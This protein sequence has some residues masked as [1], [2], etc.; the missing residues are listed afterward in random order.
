MFDPFAYQISRRDRGVV[1]NKIRGVVVDNVD[2]D[3]DNP[4]GRI[5]VRAR[6]IHDQFPDDHL[7]WSM[8][9]EGFGAGTA[10]SGKKDIPPIGAI[11]F[12]SHQDD[13][14]YHP[15][16]HDGPSTDDKNIK[17]LDHNTPG[18]VD[19]AGNLHSRAYGENNDQ[20]IITD[21]HQS[22]TGRVINTDGSITDNTVKDHSHSVFGDST[23]NNAQ[24]KIETTY[25]DEG[26]TIKA[27]KFIVD[28]EEIIFKTANFNAMKPVGGSPNSKLGSAPSAPGA[29][30]KPTFNK[31]TGD[32]Y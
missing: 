24:K 26:H 15:Q 12:I 5:K 17:E 29:R 6:D 20:N 30:T 11:V 7:P 31:P 4:R 14:L 13:S 27:K 16:Y 19:R 18:H 32:S 9:H 3:K 10:G 23:V 25:G 2:P 21:T 22:G 8:P 1:G 28:A